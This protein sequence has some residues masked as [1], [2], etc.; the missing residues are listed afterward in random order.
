M[1]N[2]KVPPPPIQ[3]NPAPPGFNLPQVKPLEP[4]T[5]GYQQSAMVSTQKQYDKQ[6]HLVTNLQGGKKKLKGGTTSNQYSVP[7][8]QMA[9]SCSGGPSQCPN[10]V[11]QDSSATGTQ[12]N[13]NRVYDNLIGKLPNGQTA[14]T[15][16][17]SSEQTKCWGCYS[18]GKKN[19]RKRFSF[20]KN[21]KFNKKRKTKKNRK[22][23]KYKSQKK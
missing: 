15:R 22:N 17:C 3:A 2:S 11:I 23:K 10:S 20:G 6:A 13:A 8:F 18:G 14:G 9:Y 19:T 21:K 4:G 16:I 5:S 7:Q 12:G 1:S